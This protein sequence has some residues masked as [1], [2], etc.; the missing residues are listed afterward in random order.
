MNSL[1]QNNLIMIWSMLPPH[2][3]GRSLLVLIMTVIGAG[4]EMIGLGMVLPVLS[5]ILTPGTLVDFGLPAFG[6][7]LL[8]TLPH[9]HLVAASMTSLVVVYM[10]KGLY[11]AGLGWVQARYAYA[12]KASVSDRLL[13]NYM[14]ADYEF[15]VQENSAQLIRN[16]TAE[17]EQFVS[18]AIVPAIRLISELFIISAIAML[19]V[20]INPMASIY[21]GMIVCMS[22]VIFHRLTNR[23]LTEWGRRRQEAEGSRIQKAQEALGGAKDAKLLKRENWFLSEYSKSNW[24]SSRMARNQLALSQIPYIWLE[25]VAIGALSFMVIY[26]V[27]TGLSISQV[28]PLLGLFGAAAFR[29]IPSANRILTALQALK[30]AAPVIKL[31][32]IEIAR[33]DFT[34]K[35]TGQNLSFHSKVKMTNVGY[36]FPNQPARVLEDINLT[37]KKGEKIGIIGKSGAG[38]STLINLFLGLIRPET[39]MLSVDGRNVAENICGWQANLGY[40]PQQ[41]FLTDNTLRRNI[42]FGVPDAEIN[43]ENLKSALDQ[44]QL[45]EFV[46]SLEDGLDTHVGERGVRLSGGQIQRIGIARALYNTPS[47]LVLD[48]ASSALDGDTERNLMSSINGLTGM[49]TMIIVTHRLSTLSDCD[50][51]YKIESGRIVDAW[52]NK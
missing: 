2:L 34:P 19:L 1:R 30:Y 31:M 32:R 9:E 46:S 27:A 25:I 11:L 24:L 16:I 12:I 7:I 44:A 48:E 35:V 45:T 20:Y 6:L 23:L 14:H 18:N 8:E 50:R 5:I 40:V 17:V 10:L 49:V 33:E 21:M 38:K 41:I 43:D 29:V 52:N 15:H 13:S 42:A 51:I 39:G 22:M 36:R 26:S 37:I 47:I 3:R 28:I 4:A